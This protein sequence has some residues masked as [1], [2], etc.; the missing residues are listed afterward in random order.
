MIDEIYNKNVLRLA[1]NISRTEPLPSPA[2]RVSLRSPLCGST[3]AVGFCTQNG[4]ISE[5]GQTIKAC[6]L[7]QASASVMAT[8]II[9]KNA[10]DI[11]SVRNNL[12]AMLKEDGPSPGGIWEA[13]SALSP[14]KEVK[15]RHGAILLPFDAVLKGLKDLKTGD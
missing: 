15:P 1:A 2:V 7:G 11:Q 12:E 8:N 13:L 14:A 3:I 4:R 5:F 10:N 6:A 9:G